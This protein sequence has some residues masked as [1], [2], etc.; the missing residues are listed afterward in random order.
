MV[1][2]VADHEE[3]YKTM[4]GIIDELI[5]QHVEEGAEPDQAVCDA[6]NGALR[7]K[8]HDGELLVPAQVKLPLT[9]NLTL[10][11]TLTP[12]TTLTLALTL[13]P[14]QVKLSRGHDGKVQLGI[15]LGSGKVSGK[16][17]GG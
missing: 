9:L 15:E 12:T 6:I 17:T 14:E 2:V 3:T 11:L 1:A 8:F 16:G 13:I 10:T 7:E 4:V 5:S